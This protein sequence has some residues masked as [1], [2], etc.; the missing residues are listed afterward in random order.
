[1]SPFVKLQPG[2]VTFGEHNIKFPHASL[3]ATAVGWRYQSSRITRGDG[4]CFPSWSSFA[5][6][7]T[8][9]DT[10]VSRAVPFPT[11]SRPFLLFLSDEKMTGDAFPR[12]TDRWRRS[13]FR[14]PPP[15]LAEQLLLAAQA[16]GSFAHSSQWPLHCGGV[17]CSTASCCCWFAFTAHK[18]SYHGIVANKNVHFFP[19]VILLNPLRIHLSFVVWMRRIYWL[20]LLL[21]L[22]SGEELLCSKAAELLCGGFTLGV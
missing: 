20:T 19:P 5:A 22:Q 7:T 14:L 16:P 21:P 17:Q 1:M 10:D 8:A 2:Y 18:V 11:F 6:S 9:S 15:Q 3:V 12:T 13:S 4:V